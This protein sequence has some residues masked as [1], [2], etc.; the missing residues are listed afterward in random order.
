MPNDLLSLSFKDEPWKYMYTVHSNTLKSYTFAADGHD[1]FICDSDLGRY[2]PA[3]ETEGA[4]ALNAVEGGP[5]GQKGGR[6]D[7]LKVPPS[8]KLR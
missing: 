6:N 2:V 7:S 1:P 5:K 4:P 3:D 8:S